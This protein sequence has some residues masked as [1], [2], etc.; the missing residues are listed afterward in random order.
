[1]MRTSC[2]RQWSGDA[3]PKRESM[4]EQQMDVCPFERTRNLTFINYARLV[5]ISSCQRSL[6][7][8]SMKSHLNGVAVD[9]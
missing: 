5:A 4:R 9:I 8:P 2:E 6:V 7:L 1:M 3:V